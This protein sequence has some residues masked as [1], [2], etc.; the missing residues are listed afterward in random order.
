MRAFIEWDDSQL[1]RLGN[2]SAAFYW[3][4]V[5]EY[6]S[7][8][9]PA[10]AESIRYACLEPWFDPRLL[11]QRHVVDH[12]T[13]STLTVRRYGVDPAPRSTPRPDLLS[14]QCMLD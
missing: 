14:L 7:R 2:A 13:T 3:L 5:W 10:S 9:L 1:E 6:H 11:P 12:R 4:A 8:I